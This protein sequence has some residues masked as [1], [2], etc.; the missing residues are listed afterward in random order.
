MASRGAPVFVAGE[1][2]LLAVSPLEALFD[3][4]NDGCA[5]VDL[6]EVTFFDSSALRVFLA[7]RRR[8]RR[9]RIVSPS[10]AVVKILDI[11]ATGDYLVHGREICW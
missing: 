2:D 8:N 3:Q 9:L 11:T 10:P 4:L 6:S 5:D 1:L 7:A